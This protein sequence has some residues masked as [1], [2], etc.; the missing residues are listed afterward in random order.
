MSLH[1][2]LTGSNLHISKTS[3]GSV[4]PMGVQTPTVIGEMY[5]DT[6]A[7]TFWVATG[8][9]NVSWKQVS[10]GSGSTY[11]FTTPLSELGTVVSITKADATTN[12]Y[13]SSADW[14]KFNSGV[15]F[16]PGNLTSGTGITI[17]G[18]TGSTVTSTGTI[19]SIATGYHLPTDAEKNTW[20]TVTGKQNTLVIGNFTTSTGISVTGGTGAIIGTGVK[21]GIDATH[22][23]PT[24]GDQSTWNGKQN[25][26]I[27]GN[28]TSSTGL[29]TTNGIGSVIGTGTTVNI[30]SGYHLPTNAEK[31][32]WD[33]V[34]GKEN[35]LTKGNL[36]T[37]T[38]LT[39]TGGTESVIG[40]GVT[41]NIASGYVLPT[42][43][44]VSTWNGKE[45]VLTFGSGVTR[46]VNAV[47]NNLITGIAGGQTIIGSTLTTQA[48]SIRGNAADLT[49]GQVNFIGTKDASTISAASVVM[50]GGLSVT[51]K[52]YVGDEL[53]LLNTSNNYVGLKAASAVSNYTL[54][55]PTSTG[56]AGTSLVTNGSGVLSFTVPPIDVL[57]QVVDMTTDIAVTSTGACFTVPARM[58]GMKL[59][60][61]HAR[62]ITAGTGG[63]AN[64]FNF[65][66]NG[67]N[68]LST[69]LMINAS[70]LDSTTAATPYVIDTSHNTLA[71][72]DLVVFKVLQ[73]NTTKPKGLTLRLNFSF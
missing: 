15:S 69:A 58:S 54:T 47:A 31:N 8:L 22:Y 23:L 40:T 66:I 59:Q 46:T 24:T 13:L 37:S 19:V 30:A 11:S 10:G 53:R 62:V 65:S 34:T 25:S 42:S 60:L 50:S 5:S 18:G 56:T 73:C 64:L 27:I 48:L 70:A 55:M 71:T 49:T 33:T 43:A 68:M 7:G 26:L 29:T 35:T 36:T 28:L 44:N 3:T 32:T 12:G 4:S 45:S 9:T 14:N 63:S 67:T 52:A 20:D 1:S 6:T 21:I 38:G 17:N 61:A 72:N 51:K 39:T 2:H 57:A 16:T 41:V